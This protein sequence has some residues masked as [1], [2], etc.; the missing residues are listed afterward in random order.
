[1]LFL[2]LSAILFV[3]T[4]IDL[5]TRTIPPWLWISVLLLA[6]LNPTWTLQSALLGV[7]I[8]GGTLLAPSLFCI[9]A[10]GG[11]DIK[12]L[13]ALG[14]VLGYPITLLGLFL[15]V[16]ISL[17]PCLYHKFR[18]KQKEFAFAPY[19]ASGFI[20]AMYLPV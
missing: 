10:F 6:P 12:L 3:A 5:K 9:T 17:A 14:Y 13:A 19:I 16:T 20:A 1:M 7:L 4:V 18:S 8:G 15:A 2:A 11:G